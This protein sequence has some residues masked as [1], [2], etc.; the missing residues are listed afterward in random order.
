MN[1]SNERFPSLSS[2][3]SFTF[4]IIDIL[5]AS[6]LDEKRREY[7]S[8]NMAAPPSSGKKANMAAGSYSKSANVKKGQ[9]IFLQGYYKI[10]FEF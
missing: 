9:N 10:C 4:D 8:F 3:M 2:I 5:M 7:C 1:K 6:P